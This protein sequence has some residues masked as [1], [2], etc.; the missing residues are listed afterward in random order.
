MASLTVI[1][2]TFPENTFGEEEKGIFT[3]LQRV[4]EIYGNEIVD[5]N[6]D[7][8]INFRPVRLEFDSGQKVL[9]LIH[10]H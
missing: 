7:D 9:I 2:K 10:R 5:N 1:D 4:A 3:L 6:W 8:L